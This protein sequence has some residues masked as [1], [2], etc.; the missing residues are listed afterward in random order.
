[1]ENLSVGILVSIFSCT[2]D[3]WEQFF[4]RHHPIGRYFTPR[5]TLERLIKEK[6]FD[7]LDKTLEGTGVA[8]DEKIKEKVYEYTHVVIHTS[9]KFCAIICMKTRLVVK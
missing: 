5:L 7:V 9:Y 3:A 4:I 1:M 6:P 8:F 2:P